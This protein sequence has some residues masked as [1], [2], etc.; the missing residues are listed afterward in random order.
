LLKTELSCF[1]CDQSFK[2]IPKLK[3][4]LQQEWD[5]RAKKAK[6]LGHVSEQKRK[7]EEH[8]DDAAT[9][10]DPKRREGEKSEH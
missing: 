4:H 10:P 6:T 9:A 5:K 8:T 7:R 2:T 1:V 3:E